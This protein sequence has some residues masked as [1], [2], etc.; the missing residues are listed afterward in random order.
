MKAFALVGLLL[1]AGAVVAQEGGGN[2][3]KGG[4]RWPNVLATTPGDLTASV[5]DHVWLGVKTS[6]A[7]NAIAMFTKVTVDGQ[8]VKDLD[9]ATT[10]YPP[11][12][13]GGGYKCFTFEPKKVGKVKIEIT[14]TV[15][16]QA[17]QPVTFNVTVK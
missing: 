10:G 17:Q 2:E 14:Y 9:S 8:A 1:V 6:S 3:T 4:P 16:G 7:P 5:G 12:N 11:G 15:G 13:M